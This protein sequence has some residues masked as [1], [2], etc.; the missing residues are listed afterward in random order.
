MQVKKI[1]IFNSKVSVFGKATDTIPIATATILQAVTSQKVISKVEEYRNTGDKTLKLS[2]PC[3]IPSG[4]FSERKDEALIEHSGV[5]CIDVDA[6]DNTHVSNFQE[7]K[8]LISQIPYVAYCG[9][10]VGGKGYFLLI[11]IKHPNKHREHF[12]ACCEDF[13]RCGI[14]VDHSCINISR[15]RFMSHDPD[16]Y[17]NENATIYTRVYEEKKEAPKY[18]KIY[19]SNAGNDVEKLISEIQTIHID[20]TGSYTQ[21]LEIGAAIAS[22][23]GESG[24]SYF[25]AVS[26]YSAKYDQKATDRKYTDCMKMRNFNIS[27]LF[28]YAKQYD[29]MIHEKDIN[30]RKPYIQRSSDHRTMDKNTPKEFGFKNIGELLEYAARKNISKERLKINV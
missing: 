14:V 17:F 28:Y 11:P 2:I 13:E 27:T 16:A 7:L 19:D 21:W 26:Q 24:R 5:I 10:S 6:K 15:L 4:T 9:L 18:N 30:L 20:I 8:K 29:I 3:F 12:K 23:F 25:H 22:E 1:N